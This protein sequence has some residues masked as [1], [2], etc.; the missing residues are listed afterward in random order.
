MS[1][2][3]IPDDAAAPAEVRRTYADIRA[4]LDTQVV[5]LIFRRLAALGT[6]VLDEA[7]ERIRPAYLD[8]RIA[9]GARLVRAAAAGPAPVA[10]SGLT[11]GPLS[12]R[13]LRSIRALLATYNQNN[14]RN[15]VAFAALLGMGEGHDPAPLTPGDKPGGPDDDDV[16]GAVV[17]PPLPALGE[18][19]PAL[20]AQARRLGR[21]FDPSPDSR[22]VA[23]L[24]LHLSYWPHA[25]DVAE[26]VLAPLDADGSLDRMREQTAEAGRTAAAALTGIAAPPGLRTRIRPVAGEIVERV[27]PGGIPAGAVLEAAFARVR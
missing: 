11:A 18:L 3:Q 26:R 23:S 19:D 13:D 27:L 1:V 21:Y 15:F 5:N 7:W 12:G 2:P 16:P 14:A 17:L 10:V 20:Q 9:E 22:T 8:G 25:L 4:T 24:F 6:D